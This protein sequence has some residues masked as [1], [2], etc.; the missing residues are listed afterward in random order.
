[1]DEIC[2]RCKSQEIL[3]GICLKCG[4]VIKETS[5]YKVNEVYE[6]EEKKS[7]TSSESS[8][9]RKEPLGELIENNGPEEPPKIE[10]IEKKIQPTETTTQEKKKSRAL[11]LKTLSALDNTLCALDEDF[12]ENAEELMKEPKPKSQKKSEKFS[13]FSKLKK[14]KFSKESISEFFSKLPRTLYVTFLGFLYELW[15]YFL[16]T[17]ND[18]KKRK[19]GY[20]LGVFSCIMV[21]FSVAIAQSALNQVS[22]IFLRLAESESGEFDLIITPSGITN[23]SSF[24]YTQIVRSLQNFPN[25]EDY[26]Y[27]SPRITANNQKFMKAS[28]CIYGNKTLSPYDI[29]WIYFS[30]NVSDNA[31]ANNVEYCPLSYCEVPRVGNIIVYHS[32]SEYRSVIGRKWTRP[33]LNPGEAYIGSELSI[34]LNVQ[35]GDI[36]LVQYSD[37]NM[38]GPLREV[39]VITDETKTFNYRTY[40]PVK[41]V[42]V[43]D[44]PLGKSPG[45]LDSNYLY[46]EYTN[47]MP[48]YANYSIHQNYTKELRKVDLINYASQII[49]NLPPSRV[50]AYNKNIYDDIQ[51]MLVDFAS[52]ISYA[53]GYT[54][55]SPTY[56]LLKYMYSTRFF[57]LFIS[58]IITLIA[59]ILSLLS[60]VL[61]YS[62]LMVNVENRKFEYGILRMIGMARHNV[63]IIIGMQATL[64]ALPG[65]IIGIVLA[66]LVYIP[67]GFILDAYLQVELTKLITYDGFLIAS[68]LGLIIPYFSSILPIY[69][70]LG[71]NLQD[72]LDTG[73]SKVK[74]II[75]KIERS[76]DVSIN[77]PVVVVGGFS[78]IFG[79]AVYYAFP[80]ALVSF[81]LTL[82]LT[83]FFVLLLAMLLGLIVLSLNFEGII[84]HFITYL[85]FFWENGAIRKLIIKNLVAHRVRNRKTSIMFSLSLAFVI[86]LSIAFKTQIESLQFDQLQSKG[87]RIQISGSVIN[88]QAMRIIFDKIARE[89][90]AVSGMAFMTHPIT[91]YI[92]FSA[93]NSKPELSNIGKYKSSTI[94]I[95]GISPQFVRSTYSTFWKYSASRNSRYSIVEQLYSS[96]GSSTAIIGKVL[97][98]NLK[99]DIDTPFSV[100]IDQRT[101]GAANVTYEIFKPIGI[102]SSIPFF[103]ATQFPFDSDDQDILVSLPTFLRLVKA[104]TGYKKLKDLPMRYLLVNFESTATERDV[105]LFKSRVYREVARG[106][107]VVDVQDK[108]TGLNTAISVIDFFFIF[109]TVIAMVICFFSLISSMYTN[110]NEQTKE[111]GVL[112]AIG[113]RK[114]FI[115]RL[116]VYEALVLLLSSSLILID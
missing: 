112:R 110:I 99:L 81:N 93:S 25:Y 44:D 63:I 7:P 82:L 94:N 57:R 28:T 51:R 67:I 85:L 66:Q 71:Q 90:P 86:F 48:L 53:V 77:W 64:F 45:G 20:V 100:R 31:C 27:N 39:G 72:S 103:T 87:A 74:A 47:F 95:H 56:P 24:N 52:K 96:P 26:S 6:D 29:Q 34:G 75:Y 17:L 62:L 116:Y 32:D 83:M 79:G 58:L 84:E 109:T 89:S 49:F 2:T 11:S 111:I 18:L 8:S 36:V 16:F 104:K 42:E 114:F 97:Q 22:I 9:S 41:I 15:V 5:F 73:R 55:I 14:E 60:I 33:K 115:W 78:A 10:I 3:E 80:L 43:I 40:F 21:V 30:A 70:A 61:I 50:V 76:T 12:L 106:V 113:V 92:S 38:G 105:K 101:E 54:Q 37:W 35:V 88:N 98:D 23:S 108:L 1:M 91:S 4:S 19:V 102:V 65:W 59:T 13:S 46:L 107:S 68:A 69:D